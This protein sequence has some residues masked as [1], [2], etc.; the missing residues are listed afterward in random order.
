MG[1]GDSGTPRS[2]R[3]A[4]L[5]HVLRSAKPVRNPTGQSVHAMWLVVRTVER[6]GTLYR[7]KM[8][9]EGNGRRTVCGR[10]R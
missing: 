1:R 3:L 5:G 6:S 2:P 7:G 10:F 8:R 4:Q 9:L